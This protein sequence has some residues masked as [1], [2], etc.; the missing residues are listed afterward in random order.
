MKLTSNS[1]IL[2][3]NSNDSSTEPSSVT[4]SS[5]ENPN[6]SDSKS[7]VIAESNETTTEENDDSPSL[8]VGQSNVSEQVAP[9]AAINYTNITPQYTTNSSGTT[10]LTVGHQLVIKQSL[11]I[12]EKHMVR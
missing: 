11:I 7:T 6:V 3:E 4:K 9:F 1:G 2:S 8:L 5:T 12:K 10:Q